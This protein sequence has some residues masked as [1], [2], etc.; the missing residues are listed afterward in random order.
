[1]FANIIVV[2]KSIPDSESSIQLVEKSK[3]KKKQKQAN[4]NKTK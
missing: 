3:N 2:I 4:K 1:M